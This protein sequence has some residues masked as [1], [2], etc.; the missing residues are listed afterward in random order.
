MFSFSSGD[1]PHAF[2]CAVNILLWC[3]HITKGRL[4]VVLDQTSVC[5]LHKKTL[6]SD[7]MRL[8]FEHSLNEPDKHRN[9]DKLF[10]NRRNLSLNNSLIIRV[11]EW[12]WNTHEWTVFWHWTKTTLKRYRYYIQLNHLRHIKN[13][14]YMWPFFS[15]TAMLFEQ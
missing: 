9:N 14:A 7:K 6:G 15:K 8:K 5:K 10:E 4:S 11:L 1:S 2:Q 12:K 13:E 3:K